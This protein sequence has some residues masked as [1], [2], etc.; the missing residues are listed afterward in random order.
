ME[1]INIPP[2]NI[3][4]SL[5]IRRNKTRIKGKRYVNLFETATQHIHKL[6]K[7]RKVFWFCKYITFEYSWGKELN[8][9]DRK[10]INPLKQLYYTSTNFHLIQEV[11]FIHI[12]PVHINDLLQ[13]WQ[14]KYK[15]QV[16]NYINPLKHLIIL[17]KHKTYL[18]ENGKV[19]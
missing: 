7:D 13:I 15:I 1:M 18:T 2:L 14:S 12:S 8:T 19:C 11:L 16:R 5:Q 9:M 4:E 17:H 3:H 10:T 6:T